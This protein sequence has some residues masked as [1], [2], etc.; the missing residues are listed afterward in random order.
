MSGDRDRG[1]RGAAGVHRPLDRGWIATP[2]PEAKVIFDRIVAA[3]VALS[4]L[5]TESVHSGAISRYLAIFVV[6]ATA[7]GACLLR[8]RV[9]GADA[10]DAAGAGGSSRWSGLMLVVAYDLGGG[11]AP[12]GGLRR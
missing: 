12:R 8:Q 4:R 6:T 11:A 7:L 10:R 9:V 3:A 2:R 5:L 1:W